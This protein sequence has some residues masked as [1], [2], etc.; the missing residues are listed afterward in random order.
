MVEGEEDWLVVHHGNML[1]TNDT[2]REA[3]QG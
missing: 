2:M 1:D 3:W